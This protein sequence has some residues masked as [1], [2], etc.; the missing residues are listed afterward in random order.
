MEVNGMKKYTVYLLTPYCIYEGVEAKTEL[1]A[2]K[3]VEIPWELDLNEIY[4]L[5]AIEE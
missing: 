1:E 2:T 5:I 4:R 3:K